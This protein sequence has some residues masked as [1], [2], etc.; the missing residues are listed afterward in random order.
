MCRF[1]ETVRVVDGAAPL[2]PWH[3]RRFRA[4][5]MAAWGG[6][7]HLPLAQLMPEC[8]SLP[9]VFK[10]RLLYSKFELEWS[11]EPY[12][13]REIL[14]LEP[15]DGSGLDYH[16]KLVD[17]SKLNRLSRD[18]KKGVEILIIQ[19]GR[20]TDTSFSNVAFEDERG[21]W[22][23][24]RPL[25]KGTRRASLLESGVLSEAD[26]AIGDLTEYR[27]VALFNAMLPWEEKIILPVTSILGSQ[28]GRS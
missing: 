15:V 14:F 21:W 7:V 27:R 9:G 12:Q 6:I 13:P 8:P 4:T 11:V 26:I 3:E 17:R 23:P 24:R 5:Q 2:L 22:T 18:R 19:E 16:L 25:L 10:A 1:L 28:L 20:I